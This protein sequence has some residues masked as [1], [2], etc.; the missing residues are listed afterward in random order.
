MSDSAQPVNI[1]L[2]RPAKRLIIT[3]TDGLRHS[4]PWSY[5][6]ANCPS[7]GE[8]VARENADPLA[9][10]NKLP[11][12]EVTDIRMVGSYAIGF[13]WADGHNAGIYTWE[14]LRELAESDQVET[15]AIA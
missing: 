14:Y 4:Y 10:L 6:R 9:I 2:D 12:S 13:T 7:A 8:K 3:W 5:L 15:S 11:S 1:K